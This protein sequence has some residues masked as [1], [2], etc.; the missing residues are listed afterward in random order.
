MQHARGAQVLY[1][2]CSSAP[3]LRALH[4]AYLIPVS[5]VLV[6]F[7]RALHILQAY[8]PGL[9]TDQVEATVRKLV[10]LCSG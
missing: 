4:G 10:K 8:W 5:C 2:R 9:I 3:M 1:L 6:S 7:S